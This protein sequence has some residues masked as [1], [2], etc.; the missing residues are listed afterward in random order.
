MIAEMIHSVTIRLSDARKKNRPFNNNRTKSVQEYRKTKSVPVP[1]VAFV[2]DRSAGSSPDYYVNDTN[3]SFITICP[4][5]IGVLTQGSYVL[6]GYSSH[7]HVPDIL[8]L[9]C[10]CERATS[11]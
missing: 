2:V 6:Y 9:R 11:P 1:S 5:A 4:C 10:T 3:A 7:H 8:I